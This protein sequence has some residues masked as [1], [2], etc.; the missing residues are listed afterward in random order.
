MIP[1]RQDFALYRHRYGALGRPDELL[2][3]FD[4]SAETLA[5]VYHYLAPLAEP[6]PDGRRAL[7]H[8]DS[9][10]RLVE[11]LSRQ[12]RHVGRAQ[13]RPIAAAGYAAAA[14]VALLLAA[15]LL[16][17]GG[18]PA[19]GLVPMLLAVGAV[20]HPAARVWAWWRANRIRY[21]TSRDFLGKVRALDVDAGSWPEPTCSARLVTVLLAALMDTADHGGELCRRIAADLDASPTH[22]WLA[23]ARPNAFALSEALIHAVNAVRDLPLPAVRDAGPV[24]SHFLEADR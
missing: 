19:V 11:G 24:P 13:R 5:W 15:Q 20:A 4:R 3:E 2:I 23:K 21:T 10:E 6:T 18:A 12:V 22:T 7:E 8:I 1:L 17:V 16:G 9:A 14:L